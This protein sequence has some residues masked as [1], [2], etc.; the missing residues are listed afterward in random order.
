MALAGFLCIIVLRTLIMTKKTAPMV[1]LIF[2]PMLGAAALGQGSPIGIYVLYGVRNIGPTGAMFIFSILYF[3]ILSDAG[4]FH[5]IADKIV[6]FS[7][8]DPVKI[9]LGTSIL[10]LLLHMGGSGAVTFMVVVPSMLP[11]YLRAGLKRT[12]LA[13]VVALSSGILNILPWSG[14]LLRA[15]SALQVGIPD[16]LNPLL[17]PMCV[18]II[19]VFSLCVFRG[20]RYKENTLESIDFPIPQPEKTIPRWKLSLNLLSIAICLVLLITN[21]MAPVVIFMGAFA[22]AAILNYPNLE[23]SKNLVLIPMHVMY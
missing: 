8:T 9:L 5:P 20:L 1:A 7:G 4:T 11:L 19:F 12:T 21:A 2:V 23:M 6:K 10:T 16:L 18:G 14:P 17:L 3:G 15:S 13:A 22:F